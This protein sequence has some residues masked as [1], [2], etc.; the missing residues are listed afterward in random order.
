MLLR[1]K[2]G[3]CL[4]QSCLGTAWLIPCSNINMAQFFLNQKRPNPQRNSDSITAPFPI[5]RQ[6]K[7]SP[8]MVRCFQGQG[9]K[10]C[11]ITLIENHWSSLMALWPECASVMWKVLKHRFL[12]RP[13]RVLIRY[14]WGGP[15]NLPLQQVSWLCGCYSDH[16]VLR[17]IGLQG[18]DC[19]R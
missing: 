9:K 7:M 15:K 2:V 18:K 11:K 6:S 16:L 3:K 4:L 19:Q 8:N 12:G 5:L 13:S 1:F 17:T 14:L 10:G